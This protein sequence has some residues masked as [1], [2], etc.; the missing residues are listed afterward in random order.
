MRCESVDKLLRD[1]EAL[2][3]KTGEPRDIALWQAGIYAR[4]FLARRHWTTNAAGN[5]CRYTE[6]DLEDDMQDVMAYVIRRWRKGGY[7]PLAYDPGT[8]GALVAKSAIRH[9]REAEQTAK[10]APLPWEVTEAD[11]RKLAES[12]GWQFADGCGA[13]PA[14]DADID[15]EG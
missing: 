10:R 12:N 3:N 11:W 7:D 13:T 4:D 5:R 15:Y 8:W 9:K 6:P 14:H 2:Q 1:L